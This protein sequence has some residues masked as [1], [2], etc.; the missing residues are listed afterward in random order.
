MVPVSGGDPRRIVF[1]I[2]PYEDVVTGDLGS[3]DQL[4]E[5]AVP[6]TATLVSRPGVQPGT[7]LSYDQAVAACA[8]TRVFSR[9]GT[10]VGHKRL[11]SSSEWIDAGD[12]VVG[13]GGSPYVYGDTF[14]ETL[15]ATL[16]ATG[17][18][19]YSGT[20]PTGSFPRC[21][22]VFGVYDQSGNA[23][24]W[25]DSHI[26][27]DI[28]AWFQLA[29]DTGLELSVDADGDVVSETVDAASML[30]VEIVGVQPPTVYEDADGVL[31]I[32]AAQVNPQVP[33]KGY[34][35]MRVDGLSYDDPDNFLPIELR[36]SEID[37]SIYRLYLL[38]DEDGAP[39]PDKRGGAYYTG[40][41]RDYSNDSTHLVH[42]HDFEGTISAR[43]VC[44][45][46]LEPEEP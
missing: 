31:Y 25:A 29:A 16:T 39:V 18:Q 45:P 32:T 38:V 1:C 33:P 6:T 4:A 15:C 40:S 27:L 5:G 23:W 10:V 8:N 28:D 3:R 22:S 20:Q 9:D 2:D 41:P 17:Q 14:D 36:V 13:N 46:V 11:V 12:G 26:T 42:F 21:V 43:C 37:A 30:T 34:L 7:H 24:E 35:K 19:V 44:D